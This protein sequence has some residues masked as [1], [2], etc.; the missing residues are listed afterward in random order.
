MTEVSEYHEE[1]HFRRP[2]SLP[3]QTYS[4]TNNDQKN[5]TVSQLQAG[6]LDSSSFSPAQTV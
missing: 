4:T 2:E 1:L 3:P 5:G 6:R